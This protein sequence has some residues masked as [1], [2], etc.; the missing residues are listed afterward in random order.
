[1]KKEYICLTC[2]DFYERCKLTV[3]TDDHAPTCC[4]YKA[5]NKQLGGR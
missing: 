4:P 1:M 3:D 2:S 5:G